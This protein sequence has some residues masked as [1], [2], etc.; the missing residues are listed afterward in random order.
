VTI[1]EIRGS[2]G[3]VRYPKLAA[4][5]NERYY[6]QTRSLMVRGMGVVYLAAFG[7]LSVQVDG[8]VGSHGIL[9][10]SDYLARAGRVLGFGPAT[11]WRLPTLLWLDSSDRALHALCWG[12]VL[13]AAVLI[14][15]ILPGPCLVLLWL[16]YLSMV[17]AGQVF[18]Q[19]Q[20]DSLL[21]EA[22]LLA[23]LLAPWTLRLKQARDEPWWFAVLLVRWLVFRLMFL[24]GMVKL[25]SHDP[26]WRNWSA[27][28]YHY[29]TQP[30]PTWTSWYMHQ[31]PAW[32]HA[33]SAGFMFYAELVAPFCVFAPRPV[34]LA[35][36][37]S[38]LLLQ[39][40][41][42]TTGNYGFF[43]LLAIVLCLGVLYDGDWKWLGEKAGTWRAAFLR[44]GWF[45]RARSADG[46]PREAH[47]A[48]HANSEESRPESA[49]ALGERKSWLWPRRL[50]TGVV[51]SIIMA[52]TA[53]QT[54]ELVWPEA[55]IPAEIET[56]SQWVAPLRSANHYGLFAVMTTK[57][58]ELLVEGSE[59]GATWH[60]YHFRW[61]PCEQDRRPRFTTPH[62]P[63]LDWQMW[64]AALSGDC[65]LPLWFGRFQQR[66]L[67]NSPEVLALL[68]DNPFPL[69]PPRFVRARFYLYHFTQIGSSD[70][71]SRE[72]LG[73]SC[74]S[75]PLS[76]IRVSSS[77]WARPA[78][79][80]LASR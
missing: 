40:L 29:E 26:T 53:A 17:V 47:E 8:L 57:R 76:A 23:I 49:P 69:R 3:G 34:R 5:R 31:L 28:E 51:G 68:R 32:F 65:Q 37:A 62:L 70:W 2:G 10:V 59:D 48:S 78:P 55:V 18:L 43:N 24:S 13:L 11:Y 1:N 80:R 50:A 71:W 30:L 12:G 38:L 79:S 46:G 9:P 21:L 33:L 74:P 20:W 73:L 22:G 60:E 27:L 19:Y 72:D 39:V 54:V 4:R 41:I 35:G 67:A 45:Q 7:S 44:S 56:L 36:C 52:V 14:A 75:L 58:P 61:K 16:F 6:R 66:L 42:A 77:C 15:G 64:F 25:A 63:R